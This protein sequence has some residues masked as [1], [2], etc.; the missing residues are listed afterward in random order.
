VAE[1][2][3]IG[4]PTGSNRAISE[5]RCSGPPASPQGSQKL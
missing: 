5:M 4:P 2:I 3:K 1:D